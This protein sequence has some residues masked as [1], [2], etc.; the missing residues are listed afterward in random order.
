ME[1]YHTSVFAYGQT[2]TGKTFTMTGSEKSNNENNLGIVQLAI[3]DCF[4]YISNEESER[5]EY[6]LR[7]S[8]MEIY[9]EVVNDLLVA[10]TAS[11]KNSNG[12]PPSAPSAIR[13][14]ESKKDGVII[15]GLKEDIVTS[16]E[17]VI[18]LLA[19]GEKRRHT[20]GTFANKKS[21]RS[22][23]IFRLTVE[24]RARPNTASHESDSIASSVFVPGSSNGPVRVSTLSLVDLAGSESVKN[25]GS[26]GTRK[27]E[28]QYINKSLLT[29]GNV[30]WKLAELSTNRSGSDRE[31]VSNLD[32][33]HIPV[34]AIILI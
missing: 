17:E 9:N 7:I 3:K 22:H 24:S 13:I 5:R 8:F 27:K 21:S 26:T 31:D 15:R 11:L 2:A 32:S 6:L 20:G 25:T 1:G 19:A 18:D 34:S 10:P 14:F 30:V 28:G 33:V 16:Y 23:S 4:D 29:L 12:V